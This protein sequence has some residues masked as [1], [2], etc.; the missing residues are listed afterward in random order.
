MALEKLKWSHWTECE[1]NVESSL[2]MR[3]TARPGGHRG[4]SSRRGQGEEDL[5]Y[6]KMLMIR[7]TAASGLASWRQAMQHFKSLNAD[8]CPS[9]YQS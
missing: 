1:K 4:H 2:M 3:C 7:G 6:D 5:T 9:N 8:H